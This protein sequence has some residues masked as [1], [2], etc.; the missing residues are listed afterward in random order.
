[1]SMRQIVKMFE[2]GSVAVVGMKGRGKDTLM[3]NVIAR[4]RK[5]YLS[6]TY[7]GYKFNPLNYN[8]LRC[9]G[10]TWKNLVGVAPIKPFQW[11]YP[12][13]Y[14]VYIGDAGAIFPSWADSELNKLMPE[15]PTHMA[16]S[17]QC[18]LSETHFNCQVLGRTW[19]KIREMA[20]KFILCKSIRWFG[21]VVVQ[22]V[23]IY[24]QAESCDKAV[25]PF[26]GRWWM[27]GADLM[28]YRLAKIKYQA[29]YGVIKKRT[30]VYWN[31]SKHD[32]RVFKKIFEGVD[33]YEEYNH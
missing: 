24:E 26:P 31:L 1:M 4:R 20:D 32:T 19:L 15:L 22:T 12:D 13:G 7:Y 23:Y 16:F 21:P 14:D 2:S 28:A 8:D 27:Y 6:N 29:M 3:G 18:G 17:R 5:P 25:P 33:P 11:P 10:N 30:L 9:G